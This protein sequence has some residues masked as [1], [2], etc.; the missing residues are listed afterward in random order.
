[1]SHECPPAVRSKLRD[2]RV[3]MHAH[4]MWSV[5]HPVT[6]LALFIDFEIC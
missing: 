4:Q 3:R 2:Q 1:M 5:A 6:A